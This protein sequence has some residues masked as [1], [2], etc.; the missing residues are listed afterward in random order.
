M[1]LQ[2]LKKIKGAADKNGLK[3]VT[4]EQG[5]TLT[6]TDFHSTRLIT[7]RIRSMGEGNGFTRVCLSTGGG[8]C[9]WRRDLSLEE[10]GLP[11]DEGICMEGQ[12]P[13]PPLMPRYG[14]PAVGTLA[15]GMHSCLV[16]F[17]KI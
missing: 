2:N 15:T 14:L 7:D 17:L 16:E 12:T 4:C 11:L 8:V 3:D 13:S 5:L 1:T 9:L 6:D 10:G